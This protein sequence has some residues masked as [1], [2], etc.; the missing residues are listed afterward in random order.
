MLECLIRMY[1]FY[2]ISNGTRNKIFLYATFELKGVKTNKNIQLAGNVYSFSFS[3]TSCTT[4]KHVV[5][6]GLRYLPWDC[7][8]H[9]NNDVA[10]GRVYK[11]FP[12]KVITG[13]RTM[14]GGYV[15]YKT[16]EIDYE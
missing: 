15:V 14:D 3:C 10:S 2:T 5:S 11:T 4:Y 9:Y 16:S 12:G 8:K 6:V 13:F 7:V 1:I